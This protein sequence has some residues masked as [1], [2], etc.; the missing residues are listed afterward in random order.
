MSALFGNWFNGTQSTPVQLQDETTDN[1]T[2]TVGYFS[3]ISN[4]FANLS[5]NNPLTLGGGDDAVQ[6]SDVNSF[7][8]L[9]YFERISLFVVCIVASYCCYA[10]CFFFFPFMI[11]HPRKFAMLWSIGSLLFL[12]AFAFLNGAYKFAQ[13]LTSFERLPFTIVYTGSILLTLLFSLVWK[14]TL[15]VIICCVVQVVS[16]IAYVVSYFPLGRRGLALGSGLARSH[17]EGWLR[18]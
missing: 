9:S 5:F 16:S 13:H 14:H 15:V 4:P 12:A 17:V 2:E 8:N 6:E 11:I 18:V 7:L 1:T 10:I 3:N